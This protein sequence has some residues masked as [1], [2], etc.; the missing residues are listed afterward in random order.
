ML[1][2]TG[3]VLSVDACCHPAPTVTDP[4]GI[5]WK[6]IVAGLPQRTSVGRLIDRAVA[7]LIDR[8]AGL[9]DCL[10]LAPAAQ[11]ARETAQYSG[12][13]TTRSP[14]LASPANVVGVFVDRAVAVIVQAIA[15]L[16]A[17][18]PDGR[19]A[20]NPRVV[21]AH[22][23][24]VS[25]A[26]SDSDT[27][28]LPETSDVVDLAVAVVI[29]AIADLD[30]RRSTHGV[31]PQLL[32][33]SGAD[34][35]TSPPALADADDAGISESGH[36]V[37]HPAAVVVEPV[38]DLHVGLSGRDVADEGCTLAHQD[39][40]TSTATR[41]D[42][43]RLAC[44]GNLVHLFVAVIVDL[45]ATLFGGQD[46]VPGGV[47]LPILSADLKAVATC[48]D[49]PRAVGAIVGDP[50]V[51]G[52]ARVAALRPQLL[53]IGLPIAVAIDTVALLDGRG[54]LALTVRPVALLTSA[55]PRSADALAER[56]RATGV[57]R[58]R[59]RPTEIALVADPVAVVIAAVACLGLGLV[60]RH[61]LERT[62]RA[63]P[64]PARTSAGLAGL[65]EATHLM[66]RLIDHAIAVVI[67]PIA[68]FWRRVRGR[69][70]ERTLE[71]SIAA[72]A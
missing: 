24:A 15:Q 27:T 40:L 52:L 58:P 68:R 70:V 23:L 51:A 32:A 16:L 50:L 2:H 56:V 46:R 3:S 49:A 17:R 38:A 10:Q 48:P 12:A 44:P 63:D 6:A 36:V 47:P 41:P 21:G 14:G 13:A 11:F 31:A 19:R 53:L 71:A 34:E 69:R 55:A 60:R 54:H 57:A 67:N 30:C 65:A 25:H 42:V 18:L 62:A 22:K 61:T 26:L 8:I 66:V 7:V 39:S 64:S 59:E 9:V 1:V 72:C 35:F 43:A 5:G 28:C 4:L 37:D 29:A 33:V 20:D 45:I